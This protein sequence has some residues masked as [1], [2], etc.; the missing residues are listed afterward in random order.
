MRKRC[1]RTAVSK[2]RFCYEPA[3][4]VG[5]E[6]EAGEDVLFLKVR[7]VGQDLLVRR[8]G[9]EVA[10]HVIYRDPH[11]PDARLPATHV[12]IYCDALSVVHMRSLRC[13]VGSF[14]KRACGG[15]T[16]ASKPVPDVWR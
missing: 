14:K 1:D 7:E 12:R 11:P 15:S 3:P 16:Q 4:N 6:S 5:D 2:S 9:H 8:P 13:E 10:E